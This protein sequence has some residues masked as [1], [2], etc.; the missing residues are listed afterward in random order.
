MDRVAP[1]DAPGRPMAKVPATSTL[2]DPGE[3]E[4]PVPLSNLQGPVVQ[5]HPW[6]EMLA[7]RPP[8]MSPLAG[9]VPQDF[10]YIQFRSVN[11]LLAL[12]EQGDVWG[13]TCS[14]RRCGKPIGMTCAST[15][16]AVGGGDKPG[17][18]AV[19]RPG[20]PG[21]SRC[22]QRPVCHGRQRRDTAVSGAAACRVQDAD[23]WVSDACRAED[24]RGGPGT[25]RV[26]RRTLCPSDSARPHRA[27]LLGLS[28][29]GSA[30]AQQFA[31]RDPASPRCHCRGSGE[32][33]RSTGRHRRVCVHQHPVA[34]RSRGGGRADLPV[35]SLYSPH[36]RAATK[37]DRVATTRL[38]QSSPHA[39]TRLCPV[40]DRTRSMA[41][42][43]GG[44]GGGQVHT[45]RIQRRTARLPRCRSI[46]TGGQRTGWCLHVPWDRGR[47]AVL[48]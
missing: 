45:G 20:R 26:S 31:R 43:L 1:K 19:L 12:L 13:I 23:G 37:T 18:A 16:A 14:A 10:Y 47:T 21:D 41:R 15:A 48:L 32:R 46:H 39:R 3:P 44:A 30:R 40:S 8:A 7:G 4:K 34:I 2:E 11:K 24:A 17:P 42:F 9:Y 28:G 36:G 27:C 33:A 22:W 25:G 5:S 38:P 29:G 6:T 35:R